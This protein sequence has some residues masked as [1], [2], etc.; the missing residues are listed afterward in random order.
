M[1]LS[2]LKQKG[3]AYWSH[4]DGSPT[5]AMSSE[6]SNRGE[7]RVVI[8]MQLKR[9]FLELRSHS[10]NDGRL[11]LRSLPSLTIKIC[12]FQS[13]FVRESKQWRPTNIIC[14]FSQL[15]KLVTGPKQLNVLRPL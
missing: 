7:Y 14:L 6:C 5:S 10:D 1:D 12:Q 8:L 2:Q 9:F 13:V 3:D 4:C 11:W 15:T